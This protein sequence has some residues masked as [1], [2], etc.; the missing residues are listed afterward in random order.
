VDGDGT[1]QPR[2]LA[3]HRVAEERGFGDGAEPA[4]QRGGEEDPVHQALLMVGRDDEGPGG[5]HPL[6][7]GHLDAPVEEPDEESG[8]GLDDAGRGRLSQG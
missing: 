1:R 8:E 4:R 2:E 6:E 5:G 7:P 3:H